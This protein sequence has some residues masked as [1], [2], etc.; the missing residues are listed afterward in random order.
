MFVFSFKT[1]VDGTQKN[2]L[3]KMVLLSTKTYVITDGQEKNHNFLLKN[4]VYLDIY[5]RCNCIAI[6]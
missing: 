2:H 4:F 5:L 1:Y 6:Q 3:N